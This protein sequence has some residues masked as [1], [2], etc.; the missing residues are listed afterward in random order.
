MLLCSQE[1]II[2][3][4]EMV[5]NFN[6]VPSL[7]SFIPLCKEDLEEDFFHNITHLQV[8]YFIQPQ[9]QQK[10]ST[11]WLLIYLYACIC[12]CRRVKDPKHC[13]FSS[14]GS[15][16]PSFLRYIIKYQV[17]NG[18]TCNLTKLNCFPRWLPICFRRWVK[19]SVLHT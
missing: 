5:Y 9:R 14:S 10:D 3:L 11:T 6:H 12:W 4:R 19:N 15:K 1:W 2:L 13:L 17:L 16:I 7:N 18:G 8:N